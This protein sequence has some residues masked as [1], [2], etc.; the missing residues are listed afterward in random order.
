MTCHD[1]REQLS[2]LIDDALGAAER[3][4]VEEHLATCAEC[5]RE[6]ERLRGTVALL[7]AVEPARAPFGFVDRVLEAARPAPWPRRL[8]R[9]LLL[10]WPVKLPIEA[11]AIV[12]VAVGVVYVF[13]STLEPARLY[14]APPSGTTVLSD[15][16]PPSSDA[17]RE[18]AR[19]EAT[20]APE[21][22]PAPEATRAKEA[23][24][25]LEG[26][27]PQE[28]VRAREAERALEA[29][30]ARERDRAP[31]KQP[32]EKKSPE[33]PPAMTTAPAPDAFK[34]GWQQSKDADERR[35][36]LDDAARDVA[37]RQANAPPATSAESQVARKLEESPARAERSQE[38]AG[39][40]ARSSAAPAVEPRTDTLQ[41]PRPAAPAPAIAAFVAPDVSGRL[42]VADRDAALQNLARLLA[43]LGGVEDR[44][45]VGDE[46]PIVELTIPREAYPELLRELAALGRWQLVREAP[47]LPER[48]RVV[49]RITR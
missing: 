42:A 46:G 20:R 23:A 31:E 29:A 16:A 27:R 22:T 45:F 3:G 37:K 19:P 30:K 18:A 21:A 10:P 1:A 7:R 25:T 14:D 24:R 15:T 48:V 13:R 5:R 28:A 32:R 40:S 39:M 38:A 11:A 35:A 49:L 12:L 17:S 33:G 44:R 6:L 8:F 41:A 2:A 36:K 4:A 9:A 26:A 47:A 34:E 43:R